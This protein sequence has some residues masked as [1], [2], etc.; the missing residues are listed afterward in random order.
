MFL[1]M[2]NGKPCC[3]IIVKSHKYF[4]AEN[5]K[6]FALNIELTVVYVKQLAEQYIITNYRSTIVHLIIN[7]AQQLGYQDL[8]FT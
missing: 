8:F 5:I 4:E 6:K 1:C 2:K 7:L 3:S